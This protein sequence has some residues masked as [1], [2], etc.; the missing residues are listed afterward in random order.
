MQYG[1]TRGTRSRGEWSSR[2]WERRTPWDGTGRRCV[3]A[4]YSRFANQ[5]GSRGRIINAFP[6][7]AYLYYG[8]TGHERKP[9]RRAGRGRPSPTPPGYYNVNPDDPG[10]TVSVNQIDPNLEPPET[11]EFIVGVERQIFSDLSASLAYTHRSSR[12]LMFPR[13]R[14]CS[15]PRRRDERR[16]SV[17]RQR[18]RERRRPRTASLWASTSRTTA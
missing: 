6:G 14:R 4:S 3:R 8:W 13:F 16:L 17:L 11:D 9:P 5:L 18:E 1:A 2:A 15:A 7:A 10:S 12:N